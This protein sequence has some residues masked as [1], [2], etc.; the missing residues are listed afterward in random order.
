M[1]IEGQQSPKSIFLAKALWIYI[2]SSVLFGKSEAKSGF[3]A[4][5]LPVF[6]SFP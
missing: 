2:H 3:C 5:E 6:H 1:L 4:K